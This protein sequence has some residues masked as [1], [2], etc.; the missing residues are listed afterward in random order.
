M[1]EKLDFR[2]R[3]AEVYRRSRR[4][5]VQERFA[6]QTKERRRHGYGACGATV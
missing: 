3:L 5:I 4:R 2:R 1:L 6:D